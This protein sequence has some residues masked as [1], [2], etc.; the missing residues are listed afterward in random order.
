[1]LNFA[2]HHLPLITLLSTG[3]LLNCQSIQHG[4]TF[5]V[6]KIVVRPIKYDKSGAINCRIA[7]SS[8]EKRCEFLITH[9][10]EEARE[11]LW[12]AHK[13]EALGYAP[14]NT[15]YH[16]HFYG[17]GFSSMKHETL[18]WRHQDGIWLLRVNKD[19]FKIPVGAL[20]ID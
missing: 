20:K 16:I 3:L 15:Y 10:Q 17:G 13:I 8:Q 11:E 5:Y 2:L 19:T 12:L 14:E 1:M 18:S 6:E 7:N 9:H 4:Q